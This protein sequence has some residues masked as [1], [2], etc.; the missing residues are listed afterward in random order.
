[1]QE[2]KKFILSIISLLAVTVLFWALWIVRAYAWVSYQEKRVTM[3][4]SI[5]IVLATVMIMN[6][7]LV[8]RIAR[9]SYLL[10]GVRKKMLIAI[11]SIF[12]VVLIN[13]VMLYHMEDYGYTISTIASIENKESEGGKYYFQIIDSE[14]HARLKF[15]C[16]KETYEELKVQDC[17]YHIR[18]RRLTFGPKKAVLGYVDVKN[19]S[20]TKED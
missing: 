7:Y 17:Q 4:G 20:E 15:S 19:V 5:L 9:P 14:N 11:G 12:F 18:Y 6:G 3:L 10:T 13:F 16:D 2:K 8:F 1:M